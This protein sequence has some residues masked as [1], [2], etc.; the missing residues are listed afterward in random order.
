MAVQ[1]IA[2]YD[3][4]RLVRLLGDVVKHQKVLILAPP[5]VPS[6]VWKETSS[7]FVETG[8]RKSSN[9]ADTLDTTRSTGD[10]LGTT[11]RRIRL[12]SN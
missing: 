12:E 9:T 10:V 7:L 1:R 11:P 3:L 8:V 4:V 2:W 5:F 6:I